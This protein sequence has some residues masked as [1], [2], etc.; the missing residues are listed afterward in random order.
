MKGKY[1]PPGG[2]NSREDKELIAKQ[3]YE[4]SIQLLIGF[5]YTR[6]KAIATKN[7]WIKEEEDRKK[8]FDKEMEKNRI[9]WRN[10]HNE[11][12]LEKTV[13]EVVTA[14]KEKVIVWD[15]KNKCLVNTLT[16]EIVK[17]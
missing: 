12:Q 13:T 9:K 4:R 17:I 5:G 16:G 10:E 6:E 7:G 8:E 14:V 2:N 15:K 11:E 3:S 1:I